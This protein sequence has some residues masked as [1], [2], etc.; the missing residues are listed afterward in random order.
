[1]LRLWKKRFGH[2]WLSQLEE[3]EDIDIEMIGLT[4]R[5]QYMYCSLP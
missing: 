5:G 4:M 2:G 3:V 1:M